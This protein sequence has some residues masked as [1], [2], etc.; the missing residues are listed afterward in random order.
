[1]IVKTGGCMYIYLDILIIINVYINYFLILTTS[2]LTHTKLNR[3]RSIISALVGSCFSLLIFF[4]KLNII[5]LTIIRILSAVLII[6][7]AF[8]ERNIKALIKKSGILFLVS[9]LFAG[10]EY[11]LSLFSS[12]NSILFFNSV[13]YVNISLLTLIISTII[14][15]IVVSLFRYILDSSNETD[16]DYKVIITLNNKQAVV[17]AKSD[18]CNNLIDVFTGKPI[19]ICNSRSIE[20]IYEK[21]Y[22]TE[23]LSDNYKEQSI[24]QGWR[25]VPYNT[26]SS[27]GLLRCFKPDNVLIK[28]CL[29]NKMKNVEVYIGITSN[30]MDFAIFNP[31]LLN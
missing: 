13:M 21:E 16:K 12:K 8:N 23:I 24:R 26:I 10:I 1:M 17:K 5:L 11:G 25:I 7:I 30:E 20:S 6:F 22:L 31:K 4:P 28:D 15:Y 14:S 2:K 29:T 27:S 18:S 19:I 9:F 3:W